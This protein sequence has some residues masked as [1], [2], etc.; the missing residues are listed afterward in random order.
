MEFAFVLELQQIQQRRGWFQLYLVGPS[1]TFFS[2]ASPFPLQHP[3]VRA[4]GAHGCEHEQSLHR[5][6]GQNQELREPEAVSPT[7][8]G[9]GGHG[10][11]LGWRLLGVSIRS[12]SAIPAAQQACAQEKSAQ[13]STGTLRFPS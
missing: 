5:G 7:H 4:G 12:C 11:G 13:I 9:Q 10:A 6:D 1:L 2:F 8:P 3:A